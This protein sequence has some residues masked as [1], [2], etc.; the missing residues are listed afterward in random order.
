MRDDG[1]VSGQSNTIISCSRECLLCGPA[2][3]ERDETTTE[4]QTEE[5][6][7]TQFTLGGEN[8][9]ISAILFD[10]YSSAYIVNVP[11]RTQTA[12]LMRKML[13]CNEV[14][15]RRDENGMRLCVF[16]FL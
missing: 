7:F 14:E 9:I 8:I 2:E 3:R 4:M 11:F 13:A 12:A 16:R 1:N 15:C 5:I 10:W 6:V